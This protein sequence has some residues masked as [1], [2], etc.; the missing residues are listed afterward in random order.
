VDIITVSIGVIIAAFGVYTFYARIKSPEIFGKLQA[1]KDKFGPASGTAIHT[2]AY[3]ILP[4][5][6]GGLV[7]NAGLNGVSIM[8]FVAS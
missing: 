5:I 7:I 3:S 4:M 2:I 6:L 1:M 8:Q